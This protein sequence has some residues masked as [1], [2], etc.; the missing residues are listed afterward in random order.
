LTVFLNYLEI[1]HVRQREYHR[2]QFNNESNR[3]FTYYQS[4]LSSTNSSRMVAHVSFPIREVSSLNILF[5]LFSRT[6]KTT[7]ITVSTRNW[8]GVESIIR[9]LI[10]AVTYSQS[11][12]THILSTIVTSSNTT[13]RM[14]PVATE[15][16]RLTI[17]QSIYTTADYFIAHRRRFD[18]N[19]EH[20]ILLIVESHR[21]ED[22]FDVVV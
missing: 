5:R 21:L 13:N 4:G 6:G 3:L 7:T 19:D 20:S 8:K 22:A 15:T 9:I 16:K 17:K 1:I 18:I 10:I 11:S 12:S 14:F 2:L